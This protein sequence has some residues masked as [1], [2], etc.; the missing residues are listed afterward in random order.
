MAVVLDFAAEVGPEFFANACASTGRQA[1]RLKFFL[2]GY[3]VEF[4]QRGRV[5]R[6][7]A[8]FGDSALRRAGWSAFF[9]DKIA[10][11]TTAM[12]NCDRRFERPENAKT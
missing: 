10:N 7:D 4:V 2:S 12:E 1:T 11:I 9:R 6:S 3:W 5:S 8:D